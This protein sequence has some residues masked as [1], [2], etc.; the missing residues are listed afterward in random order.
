MEMK[1]CPWCGNTFFVDDLLNPTPSEKLGEI[2][3]DAGDSSSNSSLC[4]H[5]LEE[6]GIMNL[7]GFCE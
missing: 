1:T 7:L 3:V 4:P 5:C 6:L 2:F